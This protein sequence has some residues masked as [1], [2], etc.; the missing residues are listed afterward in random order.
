M[1]PLAKCRIPELADVADQL[2][3]AP[4]EALL[5]Q[6][7]AAER[8]AGDLEEKERYPVDWLVF[9]IT[10]HR[11]DSPGGESAVFTGSAVLAD[12]SAFVERLCEAGEFALDDLPEGSV[13][14]DALASRWNVSR[15]TIDRSRRK[16]LIARRV[17]NERGRASLYFT[18]PSVEAYEG[19]RGDAIEKAGA[20][21]RLDAATEERII[22]RAARYRRAFRCTL[23]Q[24]AVRLAEKFGRSHQGIRELLERHDARERERGGEPIFEERPDRS[25]R[26]QIVALRLSRAGGEPA[27]IA[28]EIFGPRADKRRATRLIRQARARLL[29]RLQLEGSVS[30]AF[31]RSDADEVLLAP[32]GVRTGLGGGPGAETLEGFVRVIREASPMAADEEAARAV[33]HQYL[34]ARA[35]RLLE[36]LSETDPNPTRLD[37]IE[38][39]LRWAGLLR[40]ELV[41]SELG[42]LGTTIERQVGRSMDRIPAH[43]LRP[44]LVIGLGAIGEAADRFAPFHGGRLAGAVSLRVGKAITRAID[45]GSSAYHAARRRP[46]TT[47]A[48]PDMTRMW[49]GPAWS[50]WLAPLPGL[51]EAYQHLT[52]RD[53]LI[54]GRRSGFDGEA[55]D[56]ITRLAERL[57]TTRM[58]AARYERAAVREALRVHRELAASS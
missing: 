38:T 2:R 46:A 3:F 26:T 27:D 47:A 9:R 52:G 4:H 32:A 45:D 50:A 21:S 49:P 33:A 37:E 42:V 15:K 10:G 16:G 56:T 22:R 24:A 54:I 1:P 29:R 35:R 41:R 5:R 36:K 20:F 57:E 25:A 18:P 13:D 53:R 43:R 23:N 55:P 48:M 17:R 11:P 8:L 12:L 6:V 51:R 39:R 31:A 40:T 58:H 19:R 28:H 44:L 7:E 30:P 34:R 14:A